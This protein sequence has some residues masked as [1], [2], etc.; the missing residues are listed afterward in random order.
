MGDFSILEKFKL[1]FDL[2]IASPLFLILLF[3][4]ILMVVDTLYI[5]KKNATTKKVYIIASLLVVLLFMYSYLDSVTN[6]FDTLAKNVVAIIYFPTV[7]QYIA[8]LVLSLVILAVSVFSSKM[9]PA[10]KR[11]NVFCFAI[12]TFLFFLI[13]DQLAGINI[14]LS[15]KVKIYTNNNLMIL[16][17]LSLFVFIVWMIGLTI[18]K[19]VGMITPKHSEPEPI[20]LKTT[21]YDEPVLPT[22]FE[23]LKNIELIPE[24]KVE[25]VVIKEKNESDMFTLEEYKKM[26]ELLEMMK[27]NH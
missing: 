15:N 3:G 19:I 14:D 8:T 12:N 27:E 2:I 5:S 24:P 25:Y 20:N 9:K 1:V 4:I 6:I 16:L 22:R 7:L 26:R 11:V 17:Q 10:I 18:Y 13:L 21:F 23:D